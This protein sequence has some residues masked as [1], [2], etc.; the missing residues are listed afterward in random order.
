[1]PP[2]RSHPSG[3]PESASSSPRA[4]QCH[5]VTAAASGPTRL[6]DVVN[7]VLFSREGTSRVV[8]HHHTA[9]ASRQ[10]TSLEKAFPR[11]VPLSLTLSPCEAVL[12]LGSPCGAES[13]FLFTVELQ[14]RA[15][16]HTLPNGHQNRRAMDT[17]APPV[18]SGVW[19]SFQKALQLQTLGHNYEEKRLM[20]REINHSL[21]LCGF[22]S[23]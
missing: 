10:Q 5:F 8:G 23:S 3:H 2:S 21:P 15:T 14:C 19:V 13:A 12:F 4:H 17:T 1:M 6:R 9:L 11:G 16:A 20:E 7:L 18:C 22:S